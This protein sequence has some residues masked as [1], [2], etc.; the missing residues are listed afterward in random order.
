MQVG[1]SRED[2]KSAPTGLLEEVYVLL[3]Q[4]RSF[5]D[6]FLNNV[7]DYVQN[8]LSST[9]FRSGSNYI[10]T[11][12]TS[13]RLWQRN[14]CLCSIL[15]SWGQERLFICAVIITN[16]IKAQTYHIFVT[17]HQ[18]LWS[19]LLLLEQWSHL[20]QKEKDA[21]WATSQTWTPDRHDHVI[22][23]CSVAADAI[24]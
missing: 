15:L 22:N 2:S 16:S 10:V 9:F 23:V 3:Y 21:L 7:I 4:L 1:D 13:F 24:S 8:C 19:L 6:V 18:L 5:T 11:G 20:E 17:T 14:Q 12:D